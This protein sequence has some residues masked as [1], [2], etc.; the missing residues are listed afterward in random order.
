MATA[1]RKRRNRAPRRR[2]PAGKLL[3]MI[4]M[5][6]VPQALHVVAVLAI[7]DSLA[8]RDSRDFIETPMIFH[9]VVAGFRFARSES[10]WES[11]DALD[12]G[13]PDGVARVSA[14]RANSIMGVLMPWL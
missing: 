14:V 5:R 7:A 4:A 1:M 11:A 3:E 6:H 13:C 8:D 9:N 2:T 10:D 12:H